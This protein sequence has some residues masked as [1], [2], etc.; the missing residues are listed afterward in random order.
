MRDRLACERR[1]C[2]ANSVRRVS[3]LA[4]GSGV[5]LRS[6]MTCPA[7]EAAMLMFDSRRVCS[8][9]ANCKSLRVASQSG[10]MWSRALAQ[11][12]RIRSVKRRPV[13]VLYAL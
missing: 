12:S 8:W 7:T 13:M 10:S 2:I 9:I 3:G 1:A 4:A 11:S 6:T 5:F